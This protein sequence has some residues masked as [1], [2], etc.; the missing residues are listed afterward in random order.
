VLARVSRHCLAYVA[1]MPEDK[2]T[3]HRR[4]LGAELR[5]RR[6]AAGFNGKD[7]A[8]RL[9][10]STTKVS[11]VEVGARP[12]SEADLIMYLASC[13]LSEIEVGPILELG[14]EGSQNH[15]LK[16]HGKKLPDELKTLIFHETTAAEIHS[17]ELAFMPGLL[18]TEEYAR[19]LFIEGDRF[20]RG[21]IELRI[22]A[23]MARQRLL[24]K[25][26]P[27]DCTFYLHQNAVRASIGSA[28]I[29]HE[30]LLHLVFSSGREHCHVRLIPETSGG[31]G[32]AH[33]SFQLM[34]YVEN[35]PV[36][37]VEQ[38]AVSLF[39][40]R[41]EHSDHFR[42][43]LSRLEQAALDEGES[44]RVLADLASEFDRAAGGS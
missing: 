29:M 11:R 40:D 12:I 16:S 35:D 37:Y 43:V 41:P 7:M 20:D 22:R 8:L 36:V 38:E 30:Q 19:A 39:L 23:R 2:V 13:G 26:A 9:G 44:R 18:Q 5:R 6:E 4:E 21:S 25:T 1:G 17:Y 32:L 28:Q 34:R 3:A 27:P 42:K 10:W 24:K 31:R 15:R 14:R 33:G